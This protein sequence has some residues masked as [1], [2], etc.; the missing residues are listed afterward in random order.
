MPART[1]E[2][3]N[4]PSVVEWFKVFKFHGLDDIHLSSGEDD[5]YTDCPFCGAKPKKFSISK[6]TT[7]FR[8]FICGVSGNEHT[9]VREIWESSFAVMKTKAYEKFAKE[10]GLLHIDTARDWG[11]CL[12]LQTDEWCLPGYNKEG[13]VTGLYNWRNMKMDGVW[14]RKLLPSPR[15]GHH[16]FGLGLFEAHKPKV[17][18]CEGWRDG[19]VWYELLKHHKPHGV[20]LL[21]DANVWAIP[22]TNSFKPDWVSLLHDKEVILLFDNDHPKPNPKTGEE[23]EV[24][25]IVGV[26]RTAS[27]LTSNSE[28]KPRKVSYLDWGATGIG[29][30]RSMTNKLDIREYL[31]R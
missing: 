30:D 17:Y 8:C 16:I 21:D 15:L 5:G 18:I 25:G 4:E 28:Y 19:L 11:V 22:G 27:I 2:L 7:K 23:M 13:K 12:N 24:G 1:S 26:K 14:K 29:Y 6:D 10:S 9:F 3:T 20:P 31:T